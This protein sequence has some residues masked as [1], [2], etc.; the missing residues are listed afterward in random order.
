MTDPETSSWAKSLTEPEIRTET[1]SPDRVELTLF[2]PADLFQFKGHFPDQPILPG[3]AQL[4]WAARLSERYFGHS[5][6]FRKLGQLKFS[7]LISAGKTVTLRLHHMTEK[8]R[9]QFS[10]EIGEEVCSSGFLELA[11]E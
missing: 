7:K 2:L 10:Y 11:E 4:D 5:G 1:V 9:I 3:V 6:N 8:R